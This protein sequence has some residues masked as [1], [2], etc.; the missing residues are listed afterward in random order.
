M[1]IHNTMKVVL[2]ILAILAI[3]T[4]TTTIMAS[5][6][7]TVAATSST[8]YN[9]STAS[10]INS[11]ANSTANLTT[12]TAFTALNRTPS[13]NTTTITPITITP[14]TITPITPVTP[15]ATPLPSLW[16]DL[17]VD[18]A[19]MGLIPYKEENTSL[20]IDYFDTPFERQY[21]EHD[22]KHMISMSAR[23]TR[24]IIR[25]YHYHRFQQASST[26]RLHCKFMLNFIQ[27][28]NGTWEKE[29][30]LATNLI[31]YYRRLYTNGDHMDLVCYFVDTANQ[32][33]A[34]CLLRLVSDPH[35]EP[36]PVVE[37][38]SVRR[39]GGAFLKGEPK[40]SHYHPHNSKLQTSTTFVPFNWR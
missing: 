21:Y 5:S 22:I 18:R 6:L 12:A 40:V 1:Q 31:A 13:P 20:H 10:S 38:S 14:N 25:P 37:F 33:E 9:S 23:D 24:D 4:T 36:F 2:F 30:R 28:G 17:F 34:D 39:R 26:F 8:P 27:L 11:T 15:T 19:R 32:T 16:E 7:V 29:F 35:G 3:T